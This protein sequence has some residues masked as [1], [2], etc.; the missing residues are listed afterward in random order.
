MYTKS[1]SPPVSDEITYNT[2]GPITK[3]L[4]GIIKVNGHADYKDLLAGALMEK[5][6]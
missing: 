5:Y 2:L 6:V 4:V 3:Q 1:S